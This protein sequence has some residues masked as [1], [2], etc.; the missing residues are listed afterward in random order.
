[1]I[2]DIKKMNISE[3]QDYST[4][5][6]SMLSDV[7]D[8]VAL[9]ESAFVDTDIT[10]LQKNAIIAELTPF[11]AQLEGAIAEVEY[12]IN[13]RT[14]YNM[15]LLYSNV[16]LAGFLANQLIAYPGLTS[17]VMVPTAPE[18]S[19][20]PTEANQASLAWIPSSDNVAVASYDI[21]RAVDAGAFSLLG[22]TSNSS[23]TD[24]TATFGSTYSYYIIAKDAAGNESVASETQSV[25]P[26]A[27]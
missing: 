8:R 20:I 19:S 10:E 13:R 2:R 9:A 14:K 6:T 25:T 21:Y 26:T 22:N 12:E 4:R 23:Y 5:M 17:D 3:L 1:M 7:D 27:T 11:K 15:Q 16:G 24:V 18:L